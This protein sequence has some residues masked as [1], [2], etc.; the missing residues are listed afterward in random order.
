M[1]WHFLICRDC[2]KLG[3]SCCGP[4]AHTFLTHGVPAPDERQLKVSAWKVTS[5][6]DVARA[7]GTMVQVLDDIIGRGASPSMIRIVTVVCTP[8]ALKK[9]SEGY[10]GV[11]ISPHFTFWIQNYPWL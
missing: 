10:P 5:H 9:L 11:L 2:Q 7:G 1:T 8:V 3:F 4:L 6:S